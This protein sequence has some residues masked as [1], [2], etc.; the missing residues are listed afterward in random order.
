MVIHSSACET[1]SSRNSGQLVFVSAGLLYLKG[2][3]LLREPI[4]VFAVQQH[5]YRCLYPA[6]KS[7]AIMRCRCEAANCSEFWKT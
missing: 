7:Q 6:T 5:T 2:V 3:V 4:A 1:P